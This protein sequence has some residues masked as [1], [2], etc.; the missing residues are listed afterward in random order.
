MYWLLASGSKQ[1]WADTQGDSFTDDLEESVPGSRPEDGEASS[2]ITARLL[3]VHSQEPG[4]AGE[5]RL[6]P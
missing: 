6:R 2:F 1:P 4:G 3:P 5:S